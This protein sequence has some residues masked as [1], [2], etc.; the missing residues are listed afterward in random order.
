MEGFKFK[1]DKGPVKGVSKND[2][3]EN[4]FSRFFKVYFRKFWMLMI[5]NALYI[6]CCIPVITFGPATSAFFAV[7]KKYSLER[8]VFFFSD[9][10]SEFKKNFKQS[11][12]LGII[13]VILLVSLV[14]AYIFYGSRAAKDPAFL[15]F[16]FCVSVFA[17]VALMMHFYI[18]LMLVSTNLKMK[19]IIKN[20]L[21]LSIA[22][23]KINII[24]LICVVVIVALNVAL[25]PY[26][27][28]LMAFIPVSLIGFIIAYNS[29]PIIRKYIIQPYYDNLGELNPEFEYL[30]GKEDEETSTFTDATGKY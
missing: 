16:I 25:F 13:D 9:F 3:P 15:V 7:L 22:Q 8:P 14:C 6:L 17:I 24:T 20:S 21:I 26:S 30:Y 18:Y 5:L 10:F 19:D 27:L 29:Y 28:L 2:K 23:F 1:R 12:L 11:F 4:R